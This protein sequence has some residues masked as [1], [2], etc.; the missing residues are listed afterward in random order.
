VKAPDFHRIK[1]AVGLNDDG[2][3]SLVELII[4]IVIFGFVAYSFSLM[5]SHVVHQ[6]V[7]EKILTRALF[8]A[9]EKM[10]ESIAEG[11]SVQPVGWTPYKGV[12]W[13]REVTVIKEENG[14]PT[15]I[16]VWVDIRKDGRI[17]YSLFTHVTG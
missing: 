3:F 4:T 12:E 5:Q 14:S 6:S 1:F 11:L 2:G 8:I 7:N 13:R 10:E 15:L 16:E 9:E 17:I